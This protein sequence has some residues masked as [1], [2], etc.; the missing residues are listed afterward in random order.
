MSR[1]NSTFR[2][3][4]IKFFDMLVFY[5]FFFPKVSGCRAILASTNSVAVEIDDIKA[6]VMGKA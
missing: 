3:T 2:K 6:T 1:T 5:F 4:K